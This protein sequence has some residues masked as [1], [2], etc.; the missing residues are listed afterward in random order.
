MLSSRRPL[1]LLL[2]LAAAL[3]AIPLAGQ[4]FA[5]DPP[6][7]NTG[8]LSLT[9][10]LNMPTSYYF[11]GIAQSNAGVQFEPYLELKANL[12]EFMFVSPSRDGFSSTMP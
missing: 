4:A 7:P 3:V 2:A 5:E 1:Y 10:N 6:A 9:V 11:R 12:Y 8:A